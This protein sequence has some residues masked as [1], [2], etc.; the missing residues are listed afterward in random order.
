MRCCYL[1]MNRSALRSLLSQTSQDKGCLRPN[2]LFAS[3]DFHCNHTSG[4]TG[5]SCPTQTRTGHL[6][7][8]SYFIV[9][10]QINK[11]KFPRR[12]QTCVVVW[13]TF[14]QCSRQCSAGVNFLRQRRCYRDFTLSPLPPLPITHHFCAL[15]TE[16]AFIMLFCVQMALRRIFFDQN[17][18]TS[19]YFQ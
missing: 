8:N 2:T 18:R 15:T 3:V 13:T 7:I 10:L 9:Q 4:G 19:F 14:P 1:C 16:G 17:F 5:S 11:T 12:T 6:N